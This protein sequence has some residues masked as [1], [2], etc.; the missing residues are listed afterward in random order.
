[1]AEAGAAGLEPLG[2]LDTAPLFA[3]LGEEL[4]ALLRS[5]APDQWALPTI[6][7]GWQVRDV[8]AH[9]LDSG[10]RRV[11]VD[12]DG[13]LAPPPAEP[14]ASYR[15]LVRFLDRLNAE[16]VV[17]ARRLSPRLLVELLHHLERRLPEVLGALDPNARARFAVSWAGEEESAV[18]FDVAREL[19]ER[20]HHQQQIRLAVGAPA[21]D[22]PRWSRPVLETLLRALP[23]RY[24]ALV[25][26]AETAVVV[27]VA[28]R[29]EYVYT[30][31][32]EAEAWRLW[33]GGASSPEATIALEEETAWRLLM[34]GMTPQEARA[35]A[36]VTGDARLAE[37]FFGTLAVMA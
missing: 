23:H 13:H 24:L 9:L 6:C 35:R 25:A 5:L 7:P 18:W 12:R 14:I 28:G 26:N 15:D 31:L 8:A 4:V 3:G 11:S 2:A 1:M 10:L 33:R 37:P 22:D 17:A 34:H 16:W 19:T 36:E 32:R 27:R 20:W 29:E 21:L 30:L